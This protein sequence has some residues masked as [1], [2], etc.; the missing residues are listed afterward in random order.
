MNNFTTDMAAK[1]KTFISNSKL[2]LCKQNMMLKV[3]E[4][5]AM[6]LS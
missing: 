1:S 5:K 3:L 6:N 4:K 2:R